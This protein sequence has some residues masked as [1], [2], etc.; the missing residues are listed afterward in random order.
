M[1]NGSSRK[2]ASWQRAASGTRTTSAPRASSWTYAL[3][4]SGGFGQR[5]IRH[6]GLLGVDSSGLN[7]EDVITAD[8]NSVNLGSAGFF[9]MAEEAT[10]RLVPLITSSTNAG[11]LPTD[12][13]RFLPDPAT[14]RDDFA[15]TGE[16][17]ILAARLEGELPSASLIER[18]LDSTS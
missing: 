16:T 8:L 14:L 6:L 3:A 2:G 13:F 10:A 12:R 11:V 18:S 17:Y 5:P 9:S 15:P 7:L 1:P 4:V